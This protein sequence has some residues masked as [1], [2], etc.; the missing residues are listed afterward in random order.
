MARQGRESL[1]QATRTG[2]KVNDRNGISGI[3]AHLKLSLY[4]IFRR[5]PRI[6]GNMDNV[7]TS[8]RSRMMSRIRSTNTQPELAVRRFLH[9]NGFRF[10]LHRIVAH[11][12]KDEHYCINPDPSQC[13][14]LTV[15]E[16]AR[17]QTFQ[18]NYFFAGNLTE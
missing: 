2:K 13:L 1:T 17:L 9:A 3:H 14:N 11:I 5:A 10:R 15:R 6:P 16:A 8:T 4:N 7:D 18:D 12:T